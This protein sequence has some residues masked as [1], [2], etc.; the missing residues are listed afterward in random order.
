MKNDQQEVQ[1]LPRAWQFHPDTRV[2]TSVCGA[3]TSGQTHASR[4]KEMI[5]FTALPPARS[6]WA[7]SCPPVRS[8]LVPNPEPQVDMASPLAFFKSILKQLM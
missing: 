2:N 5:G 3:R 1:F 4:P 7:I 6:Q 8:A